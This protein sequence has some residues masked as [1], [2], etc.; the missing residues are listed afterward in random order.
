MKPYPDLEAALR[1]ALRLS[2]PMTYKFAVPGI[3][4]GGGAA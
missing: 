2:A 4:R 1:D 3:P